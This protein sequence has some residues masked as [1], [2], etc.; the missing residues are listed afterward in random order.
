[1]FDKVVLE[2]CGYVH[3]D[4]HQ[5]SEIQRLMNFGQQVTQCLV[6]NHQVG[7]LHQPQ[8][9]HGNTLGRTHQPAREGNDQQQHIKQEMQAVG[10]A[11][12]PKRDGFRQRRRGMRR[13]PCQ[14]RHGQ[15]E[16]RHAYPFMIADQP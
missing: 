15:Q 13:T 16:N 10:G 3:P 7:Q 12:L 11:L 5:Q 1:M 14:T 6:F 2:G 9:D 8:I 4:Q